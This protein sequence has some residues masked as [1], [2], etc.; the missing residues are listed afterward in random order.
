M[1]TLKKDSNIKRQN[2]SLYSDDWEVVA[3][4]MKQNGL[5]KYSAAL[6]YIINDYRCRHI[7]D[8]FNSHKEETYHEY[9][10]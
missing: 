7:P 10:S 8:K 1:N 6:R 5:R 2:I 3:W 4:V 9:V